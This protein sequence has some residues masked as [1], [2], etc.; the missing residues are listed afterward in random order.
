MSYET[1]HNAIRGRFKTQIQKTT[2]ITPELLSKTT[3]SFSTSDDSINDSTEDLSIFSGY[4]NIV[5]SGASNSSNNDIFTIEEV[6]ED[7]ITVV[8][9]LTNESAGSSVSIKTAI[10]VLYDNDG[11]FEQP[12]DKKWIRFSI[13]SGETALIDLG[14]TKR[15]RTP[16]VAQASV[17]V[18][19][20]DGDKE[21]LEIADD[22]VTSFRTV[23]ADGVRYLVPEKNTIGRGDSAFFQVNVLIKFNYDD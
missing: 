14:A 8:E 5:V 20:G 22:I 1:L 16:G 23:T 9:N 10:P 15:Y 4:N 18:P 3:V 11:S 19:S 17:F 21:A 12:K 2:T 6:T 7:K 13:L